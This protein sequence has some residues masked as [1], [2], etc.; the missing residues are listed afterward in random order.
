M[1]PF[2]YYF[3]CFLSLSF[4]HSKWKRKKVWEMTWVSVLHKWF[5]LSQDILSML[6]VQLLMTGMQILSKIILNQG[7]F[8]FALMTYR[9][10]VAAFC[11][12]PFAFF[13][14]RF[15]FFIFLNTFY[16]FFW[17]LFFL[18]FW[19]TMR[20]LLCRGIISKLNLSVCF[21]LFINALTG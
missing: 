19:W 9:H 16:S 11:V 6:L 17:H 2:I 5:V 8:I 7:I 14:E 18:T 15:V 10:I 12:A 3:L 21:W 20:L 13:F 1:L 4:Q